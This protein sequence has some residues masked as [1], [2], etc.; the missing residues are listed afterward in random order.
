MY[1]IEPELQKTRGNC[2]V[3]YLGQSID[4]MIS[5]FMMEEK[6]DGLTLAIVQ[7]PYIPRVVGYG[8]SDRSQRRLASANT[9]WPIGPISQA[10][11]AV[12]VMQ[13]HERGLLDVKDPIGKVLPDISVQWHTITIL[14][15]L[16]HTSGIADY[17]NHPDFCPKCNW[18]FEDLIQL[19]KNKK[20]Q[21]TPGTQVEQ[22]ATNFLLLTEIIERV[23]GSSYHDF[24]TEHQIRYLGM[25]HTGFTEDLKNFQQ[26]DLSKLEN[27]IHQLFKTDGSYIDPTETAASYDEN[28]DAIPVLSSS[29]LRGFSDLWASAQD[30]SLWDIALAGGVLIHD[31]ENRNYIYHSWENKEHKEI[32]AVAGWQFYKHQGLMDIKGSLTGYSCFLSRFTDAK[33]LVCVTLLANKEGVDFTNL[34]RRIAAAF[35]DNLATNCNENAHYVL[36]SQFSVD[37]TIERLKAELDK[38]SIPLFAIY[39]HARNAREVGLNLRPTTV[40][41]FGSPKVGTLLM[42]EE[43]S[44]ALE[45]PLRI[46]VWEDEAGSIW[47]SFPRLKKMAEIYELQDHTIIHNMQKLLEDLTRAAANIY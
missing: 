15:L 9:M 17:R 10:F 38:Q 31:A 18:H 25:R 7:A 4:T 19:I 5:Q 20:L 16:R 29:A 36:E 28:G 47:L 27:P 32:P 33:E 2:D 6:I 22:S 45:L 3:S 37:E 13:C 42:Q 39:D 35:G 8:M 12:A 11:A 43:Q 24:I 23:S 1:R 46:A 34:G 41:V 21:F 14:D 30:V 40:L 44:I 26:E